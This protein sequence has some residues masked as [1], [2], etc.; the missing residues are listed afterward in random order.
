MEIK[1]QLSLSKTANKMGGVLLLNYVLFFLILKIVEKFLNFE[2]LFLGNFAVF[3]SHLLL[4]LMLRV[5]Y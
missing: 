4:S 3:L 5:S 2:F 1:N